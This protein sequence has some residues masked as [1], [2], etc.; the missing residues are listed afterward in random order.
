MFVLAYVMS[1]RTSESPAC[2]LC[3]DRAD[4]VYFGS[5]LSEAVGHWWFVCA[6][7]CV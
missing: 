2:D 7:V 4:A 5:L 6:Y 1:R 3:V